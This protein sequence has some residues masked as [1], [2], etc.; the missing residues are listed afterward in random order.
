MELKR[1][2]LLVYAC[3]VGLWALVVGWQVDEHFRVEDTARTELRNR[4]MVVA[5]FLSAVIRGLRFR[6]AILQERIAAHHVC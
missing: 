5:N 1:R 4:S 2:N 6:G 3:L